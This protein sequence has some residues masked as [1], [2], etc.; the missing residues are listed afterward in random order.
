M[1]RTI[2]STTVIGCLAVAGCAGN[3]PAKPSPF[4][5]PPADATLIS[6]VNGGSL[7]I[8]MDEPGYALVY[9]VGQNGG[10]I[11]LSPEPTRPAKLPAG[12]ATVALP[13][14]SREPPSARL[15]GTRSEPWPSER[16]CAVAKPEVCNK[17]NRSDWIVI[18]PDRAS[19]AIRGIDA[20]ASYVVIITNTLPDLRQAYPDYPVSFIPAEVVQS[21]VQKVSTLV[22][23]RRWAVVAPR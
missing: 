15:A 12:T 5:V 20:I 1:P 13:Q 11:Q 22:P 14:P 19:A 3:R 23:V 18:T 8:R 6:E 17:D 4:P 16:A 21:L 9:L 2:L 7:L 10:L